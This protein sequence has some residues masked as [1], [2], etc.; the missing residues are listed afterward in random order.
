MPSS[1]LSGYYRLT[2]VMVSLSVISMSSPP[3][4][5]RRFTF[6]ADAFSASSPFEGYT[7]GVVGPV[8][9]PNKSLK[10]GRSIGR[11]G[12]GLSS[13]TVMRERFSRSRPASEGTCT[14]W[15]R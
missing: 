9:L 11:S 1:S 13:G 10:S 4:S 7:A 8:S 5:V 6:P 12:I 14:T 15:S 2:H 3:E